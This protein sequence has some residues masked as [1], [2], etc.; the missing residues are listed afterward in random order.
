VPDF[1]LDDAVLLVFAVVA[2]GAATGSIRVRGISLGPAAALFI[3]LLV[4][5]LDDRVSTTP[6]LGTLRELGLALFTYTV[7]LASGPTFL[8]GLRR[9]G[10][11]ALAVTAAM[12]ALMAGLCAGVAALLDLSGASR[13][14]LFAGSTTNTPALQSAAR[15]ATDGDPV[16]AYSLAY[17]T[18]IAAMLIL[19][20]LLLGRKLPVPAR[21]EPPA[22]PPHGEPLV[23]WTVE[24]VDAT[25][26]PMG[27]LRAR[28]PGI[29]FSRIEHD[30]IVSIATTSH[31]LQGGDRVVVIGA[32]DAVEAFC[33][34]VGRRS[35]RHLPLDRSTFD[36]RRI[37]VSDRHLA[38]VRLVDLD[39]P[40]RFGVVA[41]RLRR[42]D[43][44]LLVDDDTVLQLGDRLR[45]V[46]PGAA[47]GKVASA[48]GDSEREL[49]EVDA[50]GFALG[51][52]LGLALGAVTLP[53]PGRGNLELGPGGGPLAIGLVLGAL[54]RTGPI[55]WQLP[56]ATNL[57]L[58]QL[59]ILAFL[60]CAGLGSG[61]TFADALGTRTGLEL[62]GAGALVSSVF[63][64]LLAL[65][66]QL[67]LRHDVV[68]TAGM[69]A[70]IETQ[71]AAL[72][73]AADRTNGDERVNAAYALVFPIAMI[74]KI[75]AVQFLV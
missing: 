51:V 7:G 9:G 23:N 55:T 71:P 40:G 29:R 49:A 41:T 8:A 66:L 24:I 50:V 36:F 10:V 68:D 43:D 14:G 22:P 60:A 69:F 37:L 73:L 46:G 20:T 17:P 28:Y 15:A 33:A 12:I 5:A 19:I 42:G 34:D 31:R 48:L 38:G 11:L 53:L 6:G 30:G 56:R 18:A 75:I 26:E 72:A 1:L 62:L 2:L 67:I 59:G 57:V 44:D 25:P 61:T 52:A 4:G 58:R 70:G 45:V 35:D 27:E 54:S 47:L 32:K 64:A 39:L 16:V 3:G 65:V 74:A 63:A 13:A 21:L